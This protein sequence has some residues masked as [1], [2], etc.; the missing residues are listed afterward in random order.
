MKQVSPAD[1]RIFGFTELGQLRVSLHNSADT[2]DAGAIY[3]RIVGTEHQIVTKLENWYSQPLSA[4]EWDTLE[5]LEAETDA[6][7]SI[8]CED[9]GG[10]RRDPGSLNAFEPEDCPSC[11]GT[12]QESELPMFTRRPAGRQSLTAPARKEVA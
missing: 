1:H 10:T 6:E 2:L 9:C 5:Q 4:E 11:N 3:S 12:G 8:D 7:L